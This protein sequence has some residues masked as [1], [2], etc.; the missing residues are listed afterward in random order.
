MGHG[1]S[2][3]LISPILSFLVRQGYDSESFCRFASLDTRILQEAEA[4]I[5][6]EEYDRLL[7][8]A[9]AFTDD[10][11]FGLH[12]GQS[13]ELSNLGIL[14]YVLLNCNTIGEALAAYRTYNIILCSGIDV[15]PRTNHRETTIAFRV[16]DPA[17][18]ASRQAVDGMISSLYT[19]LLKLGC[20][21]I[22]LGKLQLAYDAS[23]EERDTYMSIFGIR[24][25]FGGESNLLSLDSE[26]MQYPILFSNQELLSTF[27]AYAEET[28]KQLLYGR[29]FADQVYKWIAGCMPSRFPDVKEAAQNF[30]VSVR[31][32]QVKLRQEETTYNSLFNKA[33]KEFAVHYLKK[34]RLA[35][36][37]IA[38][39]LQFSEPSAFQSAFKK[40]TGLPP[41]EFRETCRD[42][43]R[44][45]RYH[46]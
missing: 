44:G 35:V 3:A 7:V 33:R 2:V 38:Y 45:E 39:L 29:S 21:N 18:Q 30:N 8:A 16:S 41:G 42:R 10:S 6:E 5:S 9:A 13:I 43:Q 28:R 36:A 37:E 19:I 34:T 25:E 1:L 22:A 11:C 24:P 26:V 31:M 20:R 15:E 40:W 46:K 14:G 27:E 17:R 23:E 12:L 32:L 4:R